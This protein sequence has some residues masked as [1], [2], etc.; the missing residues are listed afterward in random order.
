MAI[1]RASATQKEKHTGLFSTTH[2]QVNLGSEFTSM[3]MELTREPRFFAGPFAESNSG[4]LFH[5][6]RMPDSM[7]G[8][9]LDLNIVLQ[10]L[11]RGS[12]VTEQSGRLAVFKMSAPF[13][14]NPT[15]GQGQRVQSTGRVT[16]IPNSAYSGLHRRQRSCSSIVEVGCLFSLCPRSILIIFVGVQRYSATSTWI[17]DQR[18]LH[19]ADVGKI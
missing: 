16:L 15:L 9:A 14:R 10:D 2:E 17:E 4:T 11:V 19:D 3:G 8:L 1:R 7:F 5:S 12:E 13:Q 18:P 6:V